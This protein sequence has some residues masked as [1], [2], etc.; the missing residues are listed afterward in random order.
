[1]KILRRHYDLDVIYPKY[2][3]LV[4]IASICEYLE[5]GR[6]ASRQI[7]T[8]LPRTA[9]SRSGLHSWTIR[10]AVLRHNTKRP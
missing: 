4:P 6:R 3:S 8:P 7:L 10:P 2:R 5:S 9:S 1:M